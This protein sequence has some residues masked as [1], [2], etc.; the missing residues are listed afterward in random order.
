MSPPTACCASATPYCCSPSLL[1]LRYSAGT[2]V[3]MCLI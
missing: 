3:V 1:S 2:C